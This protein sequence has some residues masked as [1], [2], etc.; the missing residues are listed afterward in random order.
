[1]RS[2]SLLVN[3]SRMRCG[4][5]PMSHAQQ[6]RESHAQ[7]GSEE[8]YGS[9]G[10]GQNPTP[11]AHAGTAAKGGLRTF[12]G[13]HGRAGIFT[14]AD[15]N[16]CSWRS[17]SRA[18]GPQPRHALQQAKD[19]RIFSGSLIPRPALSLAQ[20]PVSNRPVLMGRGSTVLVLGAAKRPL[21][22]ALSPAK[23]TIP[24]CRQPKLSVQVCATRSGPNEW[25]SAHSSGI[26]ALR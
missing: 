4:A 17:V 11:G 24:A 14:K 1:M 16:F 23:G 20:K 15:V 9:R 21:K 22:S 8:T 10:S 13:R 2:A 3:S 19:H 5:R 7:R 18:S 6:A 12:Q 25:R 26:P